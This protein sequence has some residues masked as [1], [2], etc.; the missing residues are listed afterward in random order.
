MNIIIAFDPA[1]FDPQAAID[2]AG[3][4]NG[5]WGRWG[6]TVD[7]VC[8]PARLTTARYWDGS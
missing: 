3:M 5:L 2:A 1:S 4:P 6:K 8:V 7:G